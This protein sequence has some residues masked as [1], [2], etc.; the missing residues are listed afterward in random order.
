M[1]GSLQLIFILNHTF[2]QIL[3]IKYQSLYWRKNKWAN[4]SLKYIK[5]DIWFLYE[6][7]TKIMVNSLVK[8]VIQKLAF[9]NCTKVQVRLKNN[10]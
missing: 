4:S 5:F 8:I 6:S 7:S 2:V 10:S 1:D 9:R 3:C